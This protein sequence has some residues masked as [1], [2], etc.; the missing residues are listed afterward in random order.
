MEISDLDGVTLHLVVERGTLDPEKFRRF[1][2]VPVA[3]SK[4]LNN[5]SSLDIVERLDA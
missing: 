3:F 4:R 2:L 1:F 5:R